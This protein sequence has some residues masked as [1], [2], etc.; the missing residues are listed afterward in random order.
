MKRRLETSLERTRQAFRRLRG[1]VGPDIYKDEEQ[2]D[3]IESE[4]DNRTETGDAGV[5]G[6]DPDPIYTEPHPGPTRADQGD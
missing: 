1:K 4:Q 5:H 2:Y 6:A 3:Y